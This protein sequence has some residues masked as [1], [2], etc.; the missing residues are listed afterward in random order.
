VCLAASDIE[1]KTRID[2]SKVRVIENV[3]DLPAKLQNTRLTKRNV[4]EQRYVAVKRRRHAQRVSRCVT[5]IAELCRSSE[6]VDVHDVRRSSWIGAGD[7]AHRI[8]DRV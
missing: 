3:V 7:V 4:L 5:D 6:A 2:V 8:A 1:N